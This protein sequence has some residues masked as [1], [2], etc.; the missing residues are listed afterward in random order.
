M[1]RQKRIKKTKKEI[2]IENQIKILK[3]QLAIED[4]KVKTNL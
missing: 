4:L 3:Q 2:D 1:T